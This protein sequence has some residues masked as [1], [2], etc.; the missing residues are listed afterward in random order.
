VAGVDDFTRGKK[1]V[2]LAAGSEAE[3]KAGKLANETQIVV[4]KPA[5]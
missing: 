4:L 2:T 1:N 3:F 5:L